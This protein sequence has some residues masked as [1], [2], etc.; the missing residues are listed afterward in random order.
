MVHSNADGLCKLSRNLG[1]FE[2]I[3]SEALPQSK[4]HVVALCWGMHQRTQQSSSWPREDLCCLILASSCSALLAACLVQPGSHEHSVLATALAAIDLSEVHI[5]DDVVAWPELRQ[6]V[7]KSFRLQTSTNMDFS[8][9]KHDRAFQPSQVL[10]VWPAGRNISSV[11][12]THTGTNMS[13]QTTSVQKLDQSS[14]LR[15]PWLTLN[16]ST[17]NTL[18]VEPQM[19]T[20]HFGNAIELTDL[21]LKLHPSLAIQ[22]HPFFSRRFKK[23]SFWNAT[24]PHVDWFA[25]CPKDVNAGRHCFL[26]RSVARVSHLSWPGWAGTIQKDINLPQVIRADALP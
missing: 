9:F 20:E 1:F 23:L 3:Q 13:I 12:Y 21:S 17:Q 24:T 7:P 15:D 14:H 6:N 18:G 2:L 19:K 22:I 4:L 8:R 25:S 26:L 10:A 11:S 16:G 5:G